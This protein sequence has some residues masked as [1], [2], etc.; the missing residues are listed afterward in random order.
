MCKPIT[1]AA[2]V[3]HARCNAIIGDS[4]IWVKTRIQNV[5]LNSILQASFRTPSLSKR[6]LM[7]GKCCEE[8]SGGYTDDWASRH[9]DCCPPSTNH[10]ARWS[11][12]ATSLDSRL[13]II[14]VCSELDPAS[15]KRYTCAGNVQDYHY[16]KLYQASR[17]CTRAVSILLCS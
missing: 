15:G 11:I 8:T 14:V 13:R 2:W 1:N 5:Q 10:N 12:V 4:V 7:L 16:P 9:R 6:I 17:H 3:G